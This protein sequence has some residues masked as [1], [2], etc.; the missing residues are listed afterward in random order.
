MLEACWFELVLLVVTQHQLFPDLAK[1]LLLLKGRNV[2]KTIRQ[3][4]MEV[5]KCRLL[6]CDEIEMECLKAIVLC[7]AGEIVKLFSDSRFFLTASVTVVIYFR[8]S[9]FN[10]GSNNTASAR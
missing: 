10:R 1:L 6:N 7:N 3:L 8:L 2:D 5:N 4:E 9:R